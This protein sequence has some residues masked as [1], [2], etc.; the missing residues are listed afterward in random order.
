MP[1]YRYRLGSPRSVVVFVD[2]RGRV[3]IGCQGW[4]WSMVVDRTHKKEE[5]KRNQKMNVG[6]TLLNCTLYTQLDW[7]F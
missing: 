5:K 2:S 4:R 1:F 7:N 3:V 6:R